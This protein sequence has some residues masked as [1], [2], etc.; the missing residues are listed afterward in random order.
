MVGR[1]ERGLFVCNVNSNNAVLWFIYI[2]NLSVR[3]WSSDGLGN[4]HYY[5]N[6]I[7]LIFCLKASQE[8]KENYLR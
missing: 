7:W 1:I 8:I 2:N 6:I 3:V 5:I 4:K